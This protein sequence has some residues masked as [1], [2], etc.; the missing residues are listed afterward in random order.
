MNILLPLYFSSFA[1]ALSGVL[2]P[3]PIFT[4]TISESIKRGPSAGPRIIAG[5]ALLEGAL[6]IGLIMGLAPLLQKDLFFIVISFAGSAVLLWMAFGM[7]RSLP[8]LKLDWDAEQQTKDRSL[9]ATGVLLSI[10]NPF[11]VIWWATIGLSFMAHAREAGIFG[12]LAFYLGHETADIIWFSLV[13]ATVGRGRHFISDRLY[14]IIIAASAAVLIGFA[15]FFGW[16]GIE[17][18]I[19]TA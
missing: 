13:S 3:G 9:M 7:F 2:M 4:A 6:V 12:V 15:F 17:K 19:E 14:K 5:H 10:S 1:V 16:S 11:L 8:G 18:V